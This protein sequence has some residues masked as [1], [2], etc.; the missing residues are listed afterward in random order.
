MNDATP[1]ATLLRQL[2]DDMA[3]AVASA[4]AWT[5]RVN[6]RRRLPATGVV[7]SSNGGTTIATANH[8]VERDED[9]TIVTHDGIELPAT[10]LGRDH[11]LDLAAL[12]VEGT[13]PAAPPAGEPLIGSFAFAIGR[14]AGLSATSGVISAVSQGR[15]RRRST[16]FISTD[17]PM[18]PGFSGGPLIDATGQ[19]VGLLSSHLGRGTTLALPVDEVQRSIAALATHGRIRQGYLGIAGQ[20][21]T[22]PSHLASVSGTIREGGLL[23]IG[24]DDGGPAAQG[25]LSLGDIILTIAGRPVGDL[26]DIRGLLGPDAIGDTV[27]VTLLRGGQPQVLHVTIGEQP[28]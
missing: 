6:G 13:L 1:A 25:G 22:L 3:A 21:V 26:E 5:V 18:F 24:V 17:A 4:G 15:G 7:W 20:P 9:L 14:A 23:L 19:F 11:D 10:L 2:S 8:V 16:R 27:E 12:R 28:A